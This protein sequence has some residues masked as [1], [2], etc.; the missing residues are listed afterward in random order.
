MPVPKAPNPPTTQAHLEVE[1]IRDDLVILKTGGV[2]LVL[3]TTAVN[4]GLLSETEQDA[5]I[6]AYAA[7]LNSLTFPI[8]IVIRSKRLDISSYLELLKNQE[9]R[10]TNENLRFQI[11]KYRDFVESIIRENRVLDKRFYIV[12]PFSPLELGARPAAASLL[13]LLNPF[14]KKARAGLPYPKEYIL[15]KAKNALYPKRD[16]ITRQLAR[17]GLKAEQLTT[18]QLIELFY[19]IYNPAIAGAQKITAAVSA[20]TAPLI[21]PAVEEKEEEAPPAEEEPKE[22]KT[23]A[24][25]ATPGLVGRLTQAKREEEEEK[26]KASQ[27]KEEVE[28]VVYK[29]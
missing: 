22:E 28:Q 17:I 14:A 11:K 23:Q 21:S 18:Q 6:Y 9:E 12:I 3:Q 29:A 15:E 2:A 4:F 1:D 8:Q 20:Y 24:K 16:H 10:Q 5:T 27:K 26:A 7:F 13:D 25:T 19:D